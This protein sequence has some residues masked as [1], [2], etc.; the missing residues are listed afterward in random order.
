VLV[1]E[2]RAQLSLFLVV[3]CGFCGHAA[4]LLLMMA[5]E[6]SAA[7]NTTSVATSIIALRVQKTLVRMIPVWSSAFAKHNACGLLLVRACA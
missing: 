1:L 2:L 7:L 4:F 3:S 6:Q 5:T